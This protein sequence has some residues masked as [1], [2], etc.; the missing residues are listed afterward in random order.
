MGTI[1]GRACVVLLIAAVKN[2]QQEQLLHSCCA[3]A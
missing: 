3:A 2:L 1:K